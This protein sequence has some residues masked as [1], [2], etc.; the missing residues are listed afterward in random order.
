MAA[1]TI[2]HYFESKERLICELYDYNRQRV[3]D[4]ISQS[5]QQERNIEQQF[6]RVW[7]N[8]YEFYLRH[9]NVLIF[10]EQFVN[11]PFNIDKYPNHFRGQLYS[12]FAEGIRSRRL[13]S[14]KPELLLVMVMGSISSS[15]KLHLFGTVPLTQADLQRMV[16]VVWDGISN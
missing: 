2:Y 6:S 10:F 16:S 9:P 7:I 4:V 11:S 5:L 12:F 14:I 8:L 1:G 3:S 13:K 15:A